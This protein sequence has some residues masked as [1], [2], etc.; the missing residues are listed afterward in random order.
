VY[1][2]PGPLGVGAGLYNYYHSLNPILNPNTDYVRP[3]GLCQYCTQSNNPVRQD[4]RANSVALNTKYEVTSN[5]SI[6]SITSYDSGHFFYEEDGDGSPL[7]VINDNFYDKA[8]QFTQDLRIATNGEGRFNSLIG[9]YFFDERVFNINGLPLDGGIDANLDGAINYLDCETAG[10]DCNYVNQFHQHKTSAALYTDDSYKI[11]D[12][13]TIRGGLR[14]THDEANLRNFMSQE[15]GP[16][17]VLIANLIPGS[18]TNLSAT[19][20]RGFTTNNVSPKIGLDYKTAGGNLL[21]VNYSRGYRG[22]SF[23]GQAYFLP[24]ELSITKSETVDAYEGGFKATLLNRRLQLNGAAFFYDYR[25][26]QFIDVDPN[27]GAQPLVNLPL[28]RIY[29]AEL[30]IAARP[31]STVTING[32]IS[33]LNSKVLE[34]TLGGQ[35]IVGNALVNAPRFSTTMAVDWDIIRANWG[36]VSARLDGNYVS[37]QHFDL[38]N[39][40][41][42]SQGGYGLLNG[43]VGWKEAHGRY[44]VDLWARNIANKFYANDKIDL[45]SGFGYIYN[46]IGEPR[47]FGA[48]LNLSF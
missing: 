1:S 48:T 14:F 4:N 22:G 32:G 35:S 39:R 36:N 40:P 47:T 45:L 37:E 38:E 5:L 15:F 28:S 8:S 24:E 6:T 33:L 17:G 26:Q 23:N 2:Q 20:D 42:A 31:I 44:G 34:G 25:N 18:T 3:A 16:D 11:T 29:G 10:V 9:V 46:R 12:Q 7:N 21:Y 43:R 41:T 13:L 19:T 27:T 30:E